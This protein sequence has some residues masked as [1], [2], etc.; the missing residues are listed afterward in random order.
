MCTQNQDS[1]EHG[2]LWGNLRLLALLIFLVGLVR[3]AWVAED[4]FIT[5]RSIEN[6]FAGHGL[7]WNVAERVQTYSHPLWMLLL[8]LGRLVT[9][10]L[11]FT[12]LG[13]GA[14]CTVVTLYCIGFRL[15]LGKTGAACG[16]FVLALSPSFVDYSTSGLEA[17]MTHLLLTLFAGLYFSDRPWEKR[18]LPLALLAS[19]AA[20][21]RP[22]TLLFFLPALMG[23]VY[24]VGLIRCIRPMLLG[25]LPLLAWTAFATLYYGTPVPITAHAKAMTGISQSELIAQ[26]GRFYADALRRDPL[27]LPVIAL[28]VGSAFVSRKTGGIALAFGTILYGLY[29]AKIGGGYMG[30]RFLTPPLLMATILMGKWIAQVDRS[31]VAGIHLAGAVA[32]GLMAPTLSVL[33][34]STFSARE[35]VEEGHDIVD[36]RGMWYPRTGLLSDKRD[37]PVFGAGEAMLGL[38]LDPSNPLIFLDG[39][40][41]LDGILVGPGMHLVDPILCDP[42]MM[43]LPVASL[44]EWRIGHFARHVPAGYLESLAFGENRLSD[45]SLARGYDDIRLVTRGDIWS[46]RRLRAIWSLAFGKGRRGIQE[47][48]ETCYRSPKGTTIQAGELPESAAEGAS[49]WNEAFRLVGAGG[50]LISLPRVSHAASL[51]MGLGGLAE[52]R[53][54]FLRN[55]VPVGS[56]S[57]YAGEGMSL[58]P[59][60]APVDIS[61][62]EQGRETG[63]DALRI[64]PLGYRRSGIHCVAFIQSF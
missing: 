5:F 13:L 6:L 59:G 19:L 14:I 52:Y 41:G 18:V 61:V 10:D 37:I 62:P 24:R 39:K 25:F 9:G 8:C 16:L 33:S 45:P 49:I 7:R 31:W 63:W 46:L 38:T 34:P 56:L 30:G 11:Y 44:S 64:W 60:I 58:F 36:E 40:V 57:T 22:D 50:L 26:G 4:A 15:G 17:P 28:G 21:N 51:S 55:G 12:A 32:L 20:L 54:E 47:Y 27:L 1:S 3:T 53:L 35:A 42:L 23:A 2:R 43:R 48:V 29:L